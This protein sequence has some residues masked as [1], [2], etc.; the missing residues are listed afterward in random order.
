VVSTSKCIEARSADGFWHKSIT[1]QRHM[2]VE[3]RFFLF[4]A[5]ARNFQRYR[6]VGWRLP[7]ASLTLILFQ[8][9]KH[10]VRRS[11]LFLISDFGH[12]FQCAQKWHKRNHLQ[13]GCHPILFALPRTLAPKRR[14]LD[15]FI[16]Q[17]IVAQT[18]RCSLVLSVIFALQV[19]I[20]GHC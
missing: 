10:R 4:R 15:S 2:V 6:T 13:N 16:S 14:G 11:F 5:L 9:L 18:I 20:Q 1:W 19:A 17:E 3:Q 8:T 7:W 12:W